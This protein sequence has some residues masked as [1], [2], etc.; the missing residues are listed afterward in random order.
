MVLEVYRAD[1]GIQTNPASTGFC[2]SLEHLKS[3]KASDAATRKAMV[4]EAQ[5]SAPASAGCRR[6][7]HP[8]SSCRPRGT[9]LL[10]F[11]TRNFRLASWAFR[12]VASKGAGCSISVLVV[13]RIPCSGSE[14][15]KSPSPTTKRF[16]ADL[17]ATYGLS[18]ERRSGLRT[19]QRSVHY[20]KVCGTVF[21][22]FANGFHV[23]VRLFVDRFPWERVHVVH[24]CLDRLVLA[25]C[26]YGRV[27]RLLDHVR[28]AHTNPE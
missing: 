15:A 11:R 26:R 4:S 21:H 13:T 28:P 2:R 18:A 6:M 20:P 16:E 9:A 24:R 25:C 1:I 8:R 19:N 3:G 22:R 14:H 7:Q 10:K 27:C 23:L 5:R 17:F 12:S